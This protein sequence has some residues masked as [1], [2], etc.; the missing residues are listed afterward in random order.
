MDKKFNK[1]CNTYELF[2]NQFS[3]F[4]KEFRKEKNI[5]KRANIHKEVIDSEEEVTE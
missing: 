4:Q 2:M 5:T 1:L 3:D